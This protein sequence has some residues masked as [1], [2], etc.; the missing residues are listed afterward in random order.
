MKESVPTF[1]MIS[2]LCS[3]AAPVCPDVVTKSYRL[4]GTPSEAARPSPCTTG[5]ALNFVSDE[6]TVTRPTLQYRAFHYI[7]RQSRLEQCP[8]FSHLPSTGRGT[9]TSQIALVFTGQSNTPIAPIAPCFREL[10]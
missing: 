5:Y 1:N 8:S 10:S 9:V 2:L 7:T 3:G 4:E 6:V